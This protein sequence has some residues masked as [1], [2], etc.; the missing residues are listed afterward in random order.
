LI[1]RP[2]E[3]RCISTDR[4]R[5]GVGE[6]ASSFRYYRNAVSRHRDPVNVDV[7]A[8]VDRVA[9]LDAAAFDSLRRT[10]ALF[11]AGEEA[12]TEDLSPLAVVREDVNDQLFL[13][14]QLY[15]E[16]KHAEFFHRYWTRRAR[17]GGPARP[18]ALEPTG[19]VVVQRFVRRAVRAQRGGDDALAHRRLAG[20]SGASVLPLP[21]RG[22][23]NSRADGVLRRADGVQWRR[24]ESA[25][26]AGARRGVRGSGAT[27]DVTSGSG[28]GT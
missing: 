11:R 7:T 10:L 17:R 26:A 23:G 19:R 21:P 28:C 9:K 12:V 2:L 18:G 8:D 20:E 4:R 24:R 3:A 6:D 25:A 22:R 15:E 27:K 16:A 14:T 13:T 1:S 5:E